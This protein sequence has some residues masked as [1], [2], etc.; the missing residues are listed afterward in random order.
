MPRGGLGR[1]R[2][3]ST[4]I[5]FPSTV[6]VEAVAAAGDQ[7]LTERTVTVALPTGA[8]IDRAMLI[9]DI[10]AMND[11]ATAHKIDLGVSGRLGAGGWVVQLATM[12]DVI[13]FPAADGATTGWT[14]ILDVSA[15][16]TAAGAYGFRFLVNQSGGANSVRYTTLFILK[17]TYRMA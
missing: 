6:G 8:I 17:V 9:P 10:T 1:I 12:L 5:S 16:V 13:G 2:Y 7:N 11:S 3:G 14:G 4:E 15:L